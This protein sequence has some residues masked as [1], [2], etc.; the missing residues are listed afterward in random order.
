MKTKFEN[1]T[2]T[3]LV[4]GLDHV[5]ETVGSAYSKPVNMSKVGG[6]WVAWNYCDKDHRVVSTREGADH[7]KATAC[8]SMSRI[9]PLETP[10]PTGS[11]P[12]SEVLVATVGNA[13]PMKLVADPEPG[14]Y[15]NHRDWAYVLKDSVDHPLAVFS[16]AEMD[17]LTKQWL[18]WRENKAALEFIKAVMA[19]GDGPKGQNGTDRAT[20][21]DKTG[22]VR[23]DGCAL[24]AALDLA[25]EPEMTQ[26]EIDAFVYLT[27]CDK[28]TMDHL[29][30][31]KAWKAAPVIQAIM[32]VTG[33]SKG[34]ATETLKELRK[35]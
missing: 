21:P 14:Q 6:A 4:C 16:F 5:N 26:D 28:A 29:K 9:I 8:G 32:K 19:E 22:F 2:E 13:D 3:D 12:S 7:I 34:V 25:G 33:L 23:C 20:G 1:I 31:I 17:A 11:A 24:S 18:V 10:K 35:Q 27:T 30:S 15:G